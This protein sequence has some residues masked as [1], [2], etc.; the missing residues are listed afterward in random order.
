MTGFFAPVCLGKQRQFFC[1]SFGSGQL[2]PGIGAAF[3]AQGRIPLVE[4][5]RSA[6]AHVG[7]YFYFRWSVWNFPTAYRN[8]ES[9]VTQTVNGNASFLP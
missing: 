9:L 8:L 3:L 4:A 1:G 7:A 5:N 2:L 6:V